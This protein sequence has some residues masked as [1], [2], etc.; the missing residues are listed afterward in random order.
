MAATSSSRG[1]VAGVARLAGCYTMG[2]A[3]SNSL[4]QHK[5]T[6]LKNK[7]KYLSETFP[8]ASPSCHPCMPG[9][10][11]RGVQMWCVQTMLKPTHQP[12]TAGVAAA[13]SVWA[14]HQHLQ[15][16][17]PAAMLTACHHGDHH[18]P[19]LAGHAVMLQCVIRE[20]TFM[21]HT[22]RPVCEV[23][24]EAHQPAGPGG[25]CSTQVK[26]VD[27][28]AHTH[29]HT[30]AVMHRPA[31]LRWCL[32]LCCGGRVLAA[33]SNWFANSIHSPTQHVRV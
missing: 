4:G 30:Q 27:R 28:E 3:R 1:G 21:L 14:R 13:A 6:R 23:T 17:P 20:R 22:Q 9:E 5:Q 11:S 32:M 29:T 24:Q 33:S 31:Q 12:Y 7:P 26:Q 10:L 25:R 16:L 15:H 2:T 19:H 18:T 8:Q